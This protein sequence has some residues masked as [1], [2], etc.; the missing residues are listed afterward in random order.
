MKKYII[1][2][3]C[4]FLFMGCSMFN[5]RTAEMSRQARDEAIK[6]MKF[7]GNGDLKDA[8][9]ACKKAVDEKNVSIVAT[10]N[11]YGFQARFYYQDCM[12]EKG[13]AC[14]ADCAYTSK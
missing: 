8:D 6:N 11:M 13:F 14:V 1:I 4:L 12:I 10:G 7:T 5:Q 9:L 2:F 3:L